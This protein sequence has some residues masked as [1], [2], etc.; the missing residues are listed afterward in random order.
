Q[1]TDDPDSL[2]EQVQKIDDVGNIQWERRYV[3]MPTISDVYNELLHLAQS[4]EDQLVDL[5]N[6][7]KLFTQGKAFG[8]FDG[9]TTLAGNASVNLDT[10]PIIVFDI[11]KLSES[12]AERPL[13]QHV[14]MTW[15]WNRFVK[16]DPKSKKRIVQDE[17]WM[18]LRYKTWIDF[19]KL[20]SARGRKW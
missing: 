9:Q 1:I 4:G 2:Y 20:L 3:P 7:V 5:I 16:N 6:V 19:F 12:G 17:A 18:T 13:A 14:L 10:S 8:L 15:I 11:S